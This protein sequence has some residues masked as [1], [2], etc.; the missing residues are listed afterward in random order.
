MAKETAERA[1]GETAVQ[2]ATQ[3][4]DKGV[5]RASLPFPC[6]APPATAIGTVIRLYC[7]VV[8][9]PSIVFQSAYYP[10]PQ[11]PL[12]IRPSKSQFSHL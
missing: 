3:E 12:M 1:R 11:N 8:R 9:A 4:I 10:Q 2:H 6:T 5:P 7:M